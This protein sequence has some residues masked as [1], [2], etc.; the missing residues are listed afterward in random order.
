MHAGR[1][2]PAMGQSDRGHL[3]Q[4]GSLS[5]THRRGEGSIRTTSADRS[6]S[7]PSSVIRRLVVATAVTVL[8]VAGV[9]AAIGNS[10]GARYTR[11][12]VV[13]A[14]AEQGFGLRDARREIR[15]TETP[16]YRE[17]SWIKGSDTGDFLV[18]IAPTSSVARDLSTR[19]VRR[20]DLPPPRFSLL[21]G[22][23]YVESLDPNLDILERKLVRDAM[24][25]LAATP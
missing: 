3:G 6:F 20:L 12:E 8:A 4:I 17:G 24:R 10:G 21:E 23:V 15:G 5:N 14:F 16:L 9:V 2:P 18:Y 22:N 7:Y 1:T 19:N 11:A 25:S 13:R